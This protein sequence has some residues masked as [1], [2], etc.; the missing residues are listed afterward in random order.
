[1]N[2]G[3]IILVFVAVV[4][5]IYFGCAVYRHGTCDMGKC[6]TLLVVAVGFL[7]GIIIFLHA[8]LFL[9]AKVPSYED[10]VWSAI[11]VIVLCLSSTMQIITMFR[12][13]FA[14]KV[15]PLKAERD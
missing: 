7:T 12:E 14:K 13:L 3:I 5:V 1:M 6:F 15:D 2:E 11:A 9:K 4:A 8:Y 10:A